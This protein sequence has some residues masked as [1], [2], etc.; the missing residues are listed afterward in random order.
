MVNWK[1]ANCLRRSS[2]SSSSLSPSVQRRT[3]DWRDKV[4]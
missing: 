4:V 2:V 1:L 3:I